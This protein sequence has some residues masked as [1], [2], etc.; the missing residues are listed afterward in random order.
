MGAP[1]SGWLTTAFTWRLVFWVVVPPALLTL[2]II[3][4]QRRAISQTGDTTDEDATERASHR[5]TAGAGVLVAIAAGLLQL[6]TYDQVRWVS[7][8]ARAAVLGV[9]GLVVVT[10]RLLPPGTLR[11]AWS[12]PSSSS[13]GSSST[14]PSTGPSPTS[15]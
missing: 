6:G 12:L 4:S 3:V 15:R 10:P 11:M 13:A 5:R 2:A 1:L 7:W 14:R 8:E 9:I